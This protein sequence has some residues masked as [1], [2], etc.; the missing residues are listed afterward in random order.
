VLQIA[1]TRAGT[2]GRFNVLIPAELNH[3]PQ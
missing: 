1:E 2:D 3:L